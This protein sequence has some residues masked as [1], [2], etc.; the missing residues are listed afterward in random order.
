MQ[1]RTPLLETL[2]ELECEIRLLTVYARECCGCYE[3]L[4]RKLDRLSSRTIRWRAMP[5]SG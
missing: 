5:P 3:I 1:G 4:R 2:R